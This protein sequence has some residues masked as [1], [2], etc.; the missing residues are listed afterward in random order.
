[1]IKVSILCLKFTIPFLLHI[2]CLIS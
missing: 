2:M 1:M